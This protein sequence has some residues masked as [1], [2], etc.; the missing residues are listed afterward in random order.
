MN[1]IKFP[2]SAII[3]QEQAK[4]ALI[5]GAI[6]PRIGG[7]LLCGQKGCAKSTLVRGLANLKGL[8]VVDLPL[9]ITEDMLVGM[10]DLKDAVHFGR[11]TF[12]GG[13]LQRAH[14]NILYVD[15]VNLLSDTIVNALL[16]VMQSGI[17]RMERDGISHTHISQFLLVGSMNPEESPIRAHFLDRFGLYVEMRGIQSL[18][19]RKA[20]IKQRMAFEAD[21]VVFFSRYHA[22]DQLLAEKITAAR[23]I[24]S[25]ISVGEPAV[26]LAIELAKT[27]NAAGHRAEIVMIET[28]IAIAALKGQDSITEIDIKEAAP[29]VLPHRICDNPPQSLQPEDQKP[30]HPGNADQQPAE[31]ESSPARGPEFTP[32]L[33]DCSTP[34]D[35]EKLPSHN[36]LDDPVVQGQ[37][38]YEVHDMSIN[39]IDRT[40]RKGSGKRSKSVSG[41]RRG[42]YIGVEIPKD[43]TTDIAL[44]ATLRVAAVYQHQRQ[45]NGIAIKIHKSDLRAKK[46][47]NRIGNTILFAVDA[48]GSMGAKQRMVATKEVVLSM[49]YDAYQKRDQVGMVA[50]R[51][52]RA[53]I[54]LPITRSV[55][56]AQK[57][58]QQLPTG[59]RTP[60]SEGL[61]LAWQ[62]ITAR[63][64]KDVDMLPLLILITDGKANAAHRDADPVKEALAAATLLRNHHIPAIVIDTE[65]GRFQMGIA[66]EI[67]E[68]M[69]AQY[70]KI[71]QIRS[72][73]IGELV[74]SARRISVP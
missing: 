20:I 72:E 50:F 16:D 3:G 68:E 41:A 40:R 9:N 64:L 29:F 11:K 51:K 57:R 30:Q 8:S 49:L 33:E 31:Q 6:N 21:P 48:S 55:D 18:E 44:D 43:L 66:R 71:D 13:V 37:E 56:L 28:A 61:F 12:E 70:F 26:N 60:L 46:R 63:R 53:E 39:T 23:N 27:A 2:F 35:L 32:V 25:S 4:Q 1:R 65:K 15:E 69:R 54:L 14:G 52:D 24:V 42:R 7:V 17:N 22:Q 47:E 74:R 73:V 45:K 67:S 62:M 59:G 58:L 10:I 5:Y 34:P 38:I 19:D 36:H